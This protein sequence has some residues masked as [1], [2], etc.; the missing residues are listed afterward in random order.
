MLAALLRRR[1]AARLRQQG[2]D[3]AHIEGLLFAPAE[4][5]KPNWWIL[6]GSL[7]FAAFT[8]AMGFSNIKYAQEVIFIGSMGVIVFLMR[9]LVASLDSCGATCARGH[10]HHHLRVPGRPPAGPR[11]DLVRD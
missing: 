1:R 11:R 9:Q 5:T 7:L 8:L 10:G 6:A 3:S 4:P 2:L